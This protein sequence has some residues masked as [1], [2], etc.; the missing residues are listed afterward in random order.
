MTTTCEVDFV[1][2]ARPISLHTLSNMREIRAAIGEA[3][4]P[5]AHERDISELRMASA[6]DTV[7]LNTLLLCAF[8]DQTVDS[9]APQLARDLN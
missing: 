3:R 2:N 6:A 5:Y 4:G 1:R 8:L 7:A 9:Q